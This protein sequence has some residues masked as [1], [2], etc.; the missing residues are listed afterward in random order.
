MTY[1]NGSALTSSRTAIRIPDKTRLA[2]GEG[3][4]ALGDEITCTCYLGD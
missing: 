3:S 2:R 4:A 1:L